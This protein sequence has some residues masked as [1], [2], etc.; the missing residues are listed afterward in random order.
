VSAIISQDR[1]TRL[2]VFQL[3]PAWTRLLEHVFTELHVTSCE[4]LIQRMLSSS[5]IAALLED[6]QYAVREEVSAVLDRNDDTRGQPGVSVPY[7]THLARSFW[8]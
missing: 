5:V 8:R 6:E 7:R 3:R 4:D 2:R 1:R